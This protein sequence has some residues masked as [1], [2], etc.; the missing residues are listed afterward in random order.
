MLLI[1]LG[2]AISWN[3]LEIFTRGSALTTARLE[4]LK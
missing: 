4:I 3:N 1:Q 2:F